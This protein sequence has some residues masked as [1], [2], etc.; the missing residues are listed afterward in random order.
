MDL[1]QVLPN[2]SIGVISIFALMWVTRSFLFHLKNEK[3]QERIERNQDKKAF[4][5]LEKE[6]RD[7]I[8]I[9][10]GENTK[11]FEKVVVHFQ[12]HNKYE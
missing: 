8:M 4:R 2:L 1:L 10:L 7:K 5:E 11:A 12:V 6:V 9:Q 3:E